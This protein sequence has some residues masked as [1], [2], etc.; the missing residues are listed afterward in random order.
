MNVELSPDALRSKFGHWL[1][2]D[3]GIPVPDEI[4]AHNLERT[5]RDRITDFELEVGD[6]YRD[7]EYLILWVQNEDGIYWPEAQDPI[8][9]ALLL[10]AFQRGVWPERY[11]PTMEV[12]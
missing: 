7:P 9:T 5:L 8:T 4:S 10:Y 2:V 1:I 11:D 6:E 3:L 12:M